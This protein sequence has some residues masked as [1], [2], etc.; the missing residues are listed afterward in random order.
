[1]VILSLSLLCVPENPWELAAG[2]REFRIAAAYTT[3]VQL[4]E[5]RDDSHCH[6]QVCVHPKREG[7]RS[8]EAGKRK[9]PPD[10]GHQS[11]KIALLWSQ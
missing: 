4:N 2:E 6:S 11:P 7:V 1:M 9:E 10:P 5:A 8:M 3:N